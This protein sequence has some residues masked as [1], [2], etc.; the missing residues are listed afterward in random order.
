MIIN[1]GLL[2][3][4]LSTINIRANENI[5]LSIFNVYLIGFISLSIL[6]SIGSLLIPIN[7][8]TFVLIYFVIC[9]FLVFVPRLRYN[10]NLFWSHFLDSLKANKVAAILWLL[11][12]L[13]VVSKE[14]FVF[15]SGNYHTQ[16]IKWIREWSVVRGLGNL[17]PQLGFNPMFFPLSA[18]FTLDVM[19]FGKKILIHPVNAITY[20]V[21]L[22]ELYRLS[23]RYFPVDITKSSLYLTILLIS[24]LFIPLRTSSP[25][26]DIICASLIIAMIILFLENNRSLILPSIILLL[27]TYK[28]SSVLVII[29]LGHWLLQGKSRTFITS[30]FALALF[31]YTP[32]LIRNYYLTGYLIFP[33]AH[34]DL[35][36]AVWKIPRSSVLFEFDVIKSW[37]RQPNNLDIVNYPLKQWVP[38]WWE[39][40]DILNQFLALS[41]FLPFICIPVGLYFHRNKYSLLSIFLSATSLFWF[42]NAPDVRFAYGFIFVGIGLFIC[43]VL[44]FKEDSFFKRRNLI[45]PIVI[46]IWLL[47]ILYFHRSH[48]HSLLKRPEQLV[49]PCSYSESQLTFVESTDNL[50]YFKSTHLNTCKNHSLPCTPRLTTPKFNIVPLGENL[51]DGFKVVSP[52]PQSE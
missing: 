17:Q 14:I 44:Q 5:E 4:F 6:C 32:Y 8:I 40:L 18:I 37:A 16:N 26:P 47:C 24:L 43:M 23:K 20:S 29:L 27:P 19:A 35:F 21:I 12:L 50:S 49:F 13:V 1:T 3:S 41:Y 48:F 15:D 52:N 11:F 38:I 7:N 36:D 10:V 25:S 28:L 39:R 30:I 31:I 45:F 33:F 22:T 46:V 9:V 42:F 51:G 34:I 2:V